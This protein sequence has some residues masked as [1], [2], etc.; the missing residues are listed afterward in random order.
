MSNGILIVEDAQSSL[1]CHGE[2]GAL[3]PAWEHPRRLSWD[4]FCPEDLRG[5]KEGLLIAN[6]AQGNAKAAEFFQWLRG[7]PFPIPVFAILPPDDSAIAHEAMD[8]VD[9]FLLWPLRPGELHR[10]IARLLG[11]RSR[12][13]REIETMLTAEIGL[14]QLIGRDPAF[15]K[16]IEQIG[17][18]GANDAPVLFT[19]ETGTG[20]ELCAR[21]IHLLSTRHLGPFIPVDCGALPDHLFENELFGHARGAFT[22]AR[23][24]QKGLVA[25]AEHGTLFLDEVDSLSLTAQSKVLRLLQE[26]TY[27]ALGSDQF[28]HADVRILAATNRNLQELVEQKAFRSDLFF[29]INVLRVRLPAL[30]ERPIDIPLLSR[31]FIQEICRGAGVPRKMISQAAACKMLQ[32]EWPGNIRELYN[33]LQRAVLCSPGPQIAAAAID[34]G[35]SPESQIDPISGTTHEKFRSAKLHAIQCFERDYV[36]QMMNKH[37]GNVTRAALEAGKDRRAFGRLAK[38]YSIRGSENPSISE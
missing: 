12:D 6:A 23:T 30:R 19:G 20:K 25:L 11:P 2:L 4:C 38:K 31:H 37:A 22:D 5:G 33:I 27:R 18:F 13:L 29:R 32:Y 1:D 28:R 17:R 16:I 36:R 14:G 35:G 8:T 7:N 21:V 10:R 3:F 24:D 34:L 9:D 26:H 15:L